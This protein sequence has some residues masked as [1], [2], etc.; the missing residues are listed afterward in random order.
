M[1]KIRRNVFE[2]NSSSTH[3]VTWINSYCVDPK[4]I[5][6]DDEGFLRVPM[7]G[8]CS[9]CYYARPEEKLGYLVQLC[10]YTKDIYLNTYGQEL[11]E[12]LELLYDCDDFKSLE[13]TIIEYMDNG[14]KGIR[15][16]DDDSYGYIDDG[17]DYSSIRDFLDENRMTLIEF[18]FGGA[19]LHYDYNG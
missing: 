7:E 4:S 18:V 11:K 10:G 14:C 13:E 3:S 5:E 15:F 12:K 8:Y 9:A 16:Y 19:V 1:I 17:H 2:T 6:L